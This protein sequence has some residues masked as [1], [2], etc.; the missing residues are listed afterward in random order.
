VKVP[1]QLK[2]LKFCR[3]RFQSKA[4]FESG[5]VNKPYSYEEISKLGNENYGVLC[6]YE[7]LA[8]IDCD[9]EE[10]TMVI[11]NLFP[12]TF[13]V[14]TG[15]GGKHFYFIVP[16]L[17]KKIILNAGDDHLG[18]IQFKGQQVVGAGSIHPNGKEYKLLKDVEIAEISYSMIKDLLKEFIKEVDYSQIKQTKEDY[19]ELIKEIADKWKE[20]NRQDLALSTAGYLRK[21]KRLGV[22]TARYIITR[23]C[24]ITNDQELPMRLNAIIETYKK[25]EVDVKGITGIL[26]YDIK[27][28][29]TLQEEILTLI[30]LRKPRDATELL[31]K[32]FLQNFNVYSTRDDIKSEMW[33][34]EDGI[35]VPQGE[36]YIKEFCGEILGKVFTTTLANEVIEKIRVK[37]FIN[38]DAFFKTDNV[39]EIPILDG[40]LDVRTREIAPFTPKKIFF[41]KVPLNYV[42]EQRCPLITQFFKDILP[43]EEDLQVI[44]E[45]FGFLLL[46]EYTIEKAVMFNGIGRNGKTKTLKLME[47]FIGTPNVCNVPI[48]SMQKDNFDLEDLFGKLLNSAGDVGKTSLKDTGCFKELTGRDGVNLKRK[49]KRTL[50]FV[51]YAKHIFACNDLPIVYDNTEGFW[52]KWILIDFPFEFKTR[53][54]ILALPIDQQL[55]K[56][57]IDVNILDKISTQEELNGLLNEALDGLDRIFKNKDFSYT[58]GTEYIKTTWKRRANSFLAFCEDCLEEDGSG[59]I[60][61]F[62]L[63]KEYGAYCRKHDLKSNVGDKSIKWTLENDYFVE[64]SR[65]QTDDGFVPIWKGITFKKKN[66]ME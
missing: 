40:I 15:S 38:Q 58:K 16:D 14:E 57:E 45:M 32:N 65:K 17:E 19:S 25:D 11:E 18:E 51:N 48:G 6:G 42:P 5:W 39:Y 46:K 47:N 21:E 22:N 4:P 54:E 59:H 52:S 41:N 62:R 63:R 29:Q 66:S 24:E 56:K 10:L 64:E 37:T 35:Y 26:E 12:E 3:V 30:A 31:V 49:F 20:G 61:K 34:Y 1:K 60:A 43:D 53:K 33:I 23:V 2:D 27:D 50:R 9:K 13:T 55:N 36:S 7:N 28:K 44:F 8:V